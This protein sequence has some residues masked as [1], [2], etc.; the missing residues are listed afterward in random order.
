MENRKIKKV[1][2]L[3]ILKLLSGLHG[4]VPASN[5]QP[6]KPLAQHVQE[7]NCG[8]PQVST[9]GIKVLNSTIN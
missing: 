8:P 6:C 7:S 9:A 4:Y 5:R 1:V 2:G 3:G